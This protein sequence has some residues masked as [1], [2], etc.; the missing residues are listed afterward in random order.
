MKTHMIVLICV[1]Y[2]NI[3]GWLRKASEKESSDNDYKEAYCK[4][5]NVVL[6]AHHGDL[7]NHAKTIKHV[8]KSKSLVSQ[9]Q[10]KLS[11]YGNK[12]VFNFFYYIT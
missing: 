8:Q 5:C 1:S 3:L 4:I 6:R 7:N 9:L 2:I 10:P 12:F 11:S